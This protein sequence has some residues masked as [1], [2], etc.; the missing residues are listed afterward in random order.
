MGTYYTPER[1]KE[2]WRLAEAA[3]INTMITNNETPHV[4]Q[5][6]R[7]YLGSGGKLQW[8]AQVANRM[9]AD[10]FS[11]VDEAVKFGAKAF[12][13]HG[14]M[15][16]DLYGARDE[17]TLRSWIRHARSHK[18]PVG[19]AGHAPETHRW[20]DE[21]GLVDF[22]AVAFYNCGSLHSGKGHNF[23]LADAFRAVECVQKLKKPCIAYKIMAAGRIDPVMAFEFAFENIK[24]GD[25]VNVGMYRGDKDGMVEEN[26]S[27]VSNILT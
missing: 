24:P 7:E 2:T 13:F 9:N 26:A 21:M 25:A 6:V 27:I 3:G 12:Y 15:V 22:H 8:I 10:M 19:T 5:A 18:I 11:A 23:K 20:I 14:G 17:K 16:D 4:L 1:I